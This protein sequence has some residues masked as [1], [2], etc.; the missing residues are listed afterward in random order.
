VIDEPALTEALKAGKLAGAGLDVYETEPLPEDSPLR[1]APNLVMTPHLGA[2]T[3]DAQVR[4]AR[5]VA[6][7]IRDALL[8][9]EVSAAINYAALG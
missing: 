3:E 1:H 7:R 4:V 2:S 9:G 8:E 5:E 6:D